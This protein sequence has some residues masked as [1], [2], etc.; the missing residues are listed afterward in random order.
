MI[1]AF[2]KKFI[3][4]NLNNTQQQIANYSKPSFAKRSFLSSI[5]R[6]GQK[7]GSA[8]FISILIF[9]Y[10]QRVVNALKSIRFAIPKLWISPTNR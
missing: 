6:Q 2:L 3:L 1:E 9:F 7:D 10:K 4:E 5:R 8:F